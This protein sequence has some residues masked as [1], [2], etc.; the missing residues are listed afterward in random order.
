MTRPRT[1]LARHSHASSAVPCR[2]CPLRQLPCFRPFTA[3]ELTF[4]EQFK[5]GEKRLKAGMQI[6]EEG[7]P[8]S[9]AYTLLSGWAFRYK[10]LP[11]GRRQILNFVLPGDLLGLQAAVLADPEHSAEALTDVTLC[12]FP[13]AK[14]WDIYNNY[15]GLAFDVTWLA[16]REERFLDE[17]LLSIGRRSAAER[18]AYLLVHLHQR[19]ASLTP[20]SDVTALPLT[21]QQL[22]DALGLSLVHTNKTLR[23]LDRAG[24]VR[25]RDGLLHCPDW[26]ALADFAKFEA[27]DPATRPIL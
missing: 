1:N 6:L 20:G 10:T 21:Q 12:V 15:P 14:L 23:R 25:W 24:L 7:Q 17:H 19:I 22:A 8:S 4:V 5:Q 27:G 2:V 16:A 18:S 26:P 13:R 11:D 9:N 3:E